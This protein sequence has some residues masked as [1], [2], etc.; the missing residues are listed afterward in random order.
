MCG[1]NGLDISGADMRRLSLLVIKEN[2][3]DWQDKA[4]LVGCIVGLAVVMMD[5]FWWCG[6]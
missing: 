5:L 3:M 6:G 1:Q 4:V 2:S